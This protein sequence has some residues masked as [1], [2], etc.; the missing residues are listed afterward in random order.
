MSK[1]IFNW[2]NTQKKVKK[3]FMFGNTVFDSF[4][5][6]MIVKNPYIF[7][8]LRFVFPSNKM[9]QTVNPIKNTFSLRKKRP[10]VGRFF[11]ALNQYL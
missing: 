10:F 8:H 11:L 1:F 4:G 7:S 6:I 9:K 5:I 2:K 3:K